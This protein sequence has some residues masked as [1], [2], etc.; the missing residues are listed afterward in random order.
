MS[1]S[2]DADERA[3]RLRSQQIAGSPVAVLEGVMQRMNNPNSENETGRR[4]VRGVE[5]S[6][7]LLYLTGGVHHPIC[8]APGTGSRGQA[9][10]R[11]STA[12][13]AGPYLFPRLS[14][15]GQRE[16]RS[17]SDAPASRRRHLDL[18]RAPGGTHPADLRREQQRP[19]G[20]RTANAWSSA[21]TRMGSSN[22]YV[23]NADGS[24]K[25][26]RLTTSDHS[27]RSHGRGPTPT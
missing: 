17:T 4:S 7:P 6:E 21:P 11:K 3:I 23:V 20:R 9:P 5:I 24:G 10:G 19:S 16:S 18:R 13:P 8:R 2:P 26:E 1:G 15:D 25:P 14:P 12:V 27:T 22:L